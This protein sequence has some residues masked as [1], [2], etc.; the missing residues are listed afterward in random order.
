MMQKVEAR[1]VGLKPTEVGH[2]D[3]VVV[4]LLSP[5]VYKLLCTRVVF[6]QS[7]HIVIDIYC[8]LTIVNFKAN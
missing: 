2:V 5:V 4:F 1:T 7:V 8:F 3:W 6:L